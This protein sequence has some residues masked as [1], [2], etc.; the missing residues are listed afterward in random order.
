MKISIG[1]YFRLIGWSVCLIVL[2]LRLEYGYLPS[3]LRR[4]P[5]GVGI[6]DEVGGRS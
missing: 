1:R 4:R 6:G 5:I 2:R 3:N